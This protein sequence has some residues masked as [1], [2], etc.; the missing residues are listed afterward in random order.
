[1]PIAPGGPY[2]ELRIR[3]QN[4]LGV[5]ADGPAGG[6]FQLSPIDS[7]DPQITYG[8][9][10]STTN[11]SAAYG[12]SLATTSTSGVAATLTFSGRSIAVIA[13]LRPTYGSIQVCPDPG[14][15]GA[16]C[17]VT[18]LHS[19]TS[20]DRDV[21]YVSGPLTAGQHSIAITDTTTAPVALD[22]FVLLG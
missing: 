6:P 8:T 1:M 4:Q 2:P 21:V 9:G 15:T 14:T 19:T 20:Q 13:P 18:S 11:N 22:A 7:S 16:G 10:W 3:G 17:T 5:A 12:G